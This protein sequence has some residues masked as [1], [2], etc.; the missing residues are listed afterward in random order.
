PGAGGNHNGAPASCNC[1]STSGG[2][3]RSP[4]HRGYLAQPKKYGVLP[5][6]L[7]RSFI[8][9]PHSGQVSWISTAGI[10]FFGG[11]GGSTSLSFS[12]KSS[13][14]GLVLRHLG[15]AL[16]PRNGPRGPFLTAIGAPHFSQLTPVSIGCSGLPWASTSL[17]FLHLGYPVQAKNG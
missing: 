15:Y 4:L 14:I 17:A 9:P 10:A 12:F 1:S 5:R 3:S 16:H 11:G 6:L 13:G 7:S 2:A 8:G